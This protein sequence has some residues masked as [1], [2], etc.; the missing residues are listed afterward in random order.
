MTTIEASTTDLSG[1]LLAQLLSYPG[2]RDL[3]DDGIREGS[4]RPDYDLKPDLLDSAELVALILQRDFPDLAPLIKKFV[5]DINFLGSEQREE[6]YTHTFDIKASCT[7]EVGW[8]IFGESYSRGALLVRLRAKMRE[9]EIP[10]NGELPDHLANVLRLIDFISHEEAIALITEC[11]VPSMKTMIEGMKPENPYHGVMVAIREIFASQISHE[12]TGNREQG[13]VSE[14]SNQADESNSPPPEE[15]GSI[16]D[17][18]SP[19]KCGSCATFSTCGSV[20]DFVKDRVAKKDERKF[21]H[22]DDEDF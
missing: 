20:T 17:I 5:D 16:E 1:N 18:P 8:H 15:R 6:L 7:L 22:E 19:E 14:F 13:E 3:M 4:D 9:H 2:E 12:G 11:I 10:E 21:L